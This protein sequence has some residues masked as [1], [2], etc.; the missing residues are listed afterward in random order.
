MNC[1]DTYIGFV[2][3]SIAKD[4]KDRRVGYLDLVLLDGRIILV[5]AET[6]KLEDLNFERHFFF[7]RRRKLT[8]RTHSLRFGRESTNHLNQSDCNVFK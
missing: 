8:S 7:P 1:K 6:N 3:T 4:V 2:L 5:R